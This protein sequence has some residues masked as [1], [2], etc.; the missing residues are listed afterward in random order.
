MNRVPR[1]VLILPV[2]VAA[3][4][5]RIG[6]QSADRSPALSPELAQ[7]VAQDE[8]VISDALAHFDEPQRLRSVI[9]KAERVLEIRVAQQGKAWWE[10][11]DARQN[12]ADLRSLLAMPADQRTALFKAEVVGAQA[13]ELQKA[14]RYDQAAQ[15]LQTMAD[16]ERQILGQDH[17]WYAN[18][19]IALGRLYDADAQGKYAQAESLFKRALAIE[20]RALGQEHP[21]VAKALNDL[22]FVFEMT[23]RY[24]QAEPLCRQALEIR[25][26]ALGEKH[27]DSLD[28]LHRLALIY[29]LMDRNEEAEPLYRELADLQESISGED[30]PE[31][32]SDLTH[33]GWVEQSLKRYDQAEALYRKSL[34]IRRKVL[35]EEHSGVAENLDELGFLC[36]LQNRYDEAEPLYRQALQIRRKVLG[37]EHPDTLTSLA[38]LAAL[39]TSMTRY[40]DAEP[41]Y[42]QLLEVRRKS[43][44]EEHPDY[45]SAL[46]SLAW[47]NQ[48]MKRYDEAERL[49][50]Q[51]L[52]VR[53]RTRGEEDPDYATAL[54]DLGFLYQSQ[55]R[56]KEAEPLYR[57]A[58][59]IR[60]KTLGTQHPDTLRSLQKLADLYR[61]SDRYREAEPL[62]L[63][64][65]QAQK[66]GDTNSLDYAKTLTYLASVYHSLGRFGEEEP[67]LRQ[68]IEIRKAAG[69]D[70]DPDYARA[71]DDLGVCLLLQDRN[72]EAEPL[73]LQALEIRK[74]VLGEKH[75]DYGYSLR[76]MA[77][78]YTAVGQ[79]ERADQML[80]KAL[81]IQREADGNENPYYLADLAELY[82]RQ[83]RPD[84]AEPLF[85][86][87]LEVD[88]K[89]QAGRPQ[90]SFLSSL[91][92]FY[93]ST[94]RFG[95]AEPLLR[96]AMEIDREKLG[97][98]HPGY[99]RDLQLLGFLYAT[100]GRHTLAEPLLRQA[101][102]ITRKS[103]GEN[104]RYAGGLFVLARLYMA[105]HR[106]AEAQ[107]LL[108]QAV[109]IFKG[110]RFEGPEYTIGLT[111]LAVS[112]I[113]TG[114]REEAESLARQ[115]LA[116]RTKSFGTED[117]GRAQI[118]TVLA[119][120]LVVRSPSEAGA[121]LVEA[122][123]MEW[124]Y[125]ARNFPGMGDRQK[126]EF[127]AATDFASTGQLLWMLTFRNGGGGAE[128]G[129]RV[130]LLE[131]HLLF[132]SARQES[133]ALLAAVVAA[134][135]QWRAAWQQR[136]QLRR[137]YA[138][139]ALKSMSAASEIPGQEAVDPGQLRAFTSR[140]EQM[141]QQLRQS[142]PA[143]AL[144]AGIQ[145]IRL[146]DVRR[147]VRP[148]E[149][150]V[151]YLAYPAAATHGTSQHYGAFV[152]AG[153]SG[154]VAAID[155]GEAAAVDEAVSE[156]RA[157]VR[158]SIVQFGSVVPSRGQL[159]RSETEIAALS[160]QVRALVWQPLEKQLEGVRRVY[161]APDGQLSLIPFEALAQ[162][163]DAG[164]WRYL[165]EDRELIYLG[166]GRD[167][168]RL[169]LSSGAAA[170]RPKTAVLI[171]NPDFSAKPEQLAAEV[172]GIEPAVPAAV[173]QAA[174]PPTASTLGIAG[175]D[176]A[177]RLKIPRQWDRR[178]ELTKLVEGAGTQL[179][180]LG[181][182]VELL[183]GAA[184]VKEA[185][186][187][188]KAPRILQFATHGY[189][190]DRPRGEGASWDNPLLRSMLILA[191]ANDW[192]PVYRVGREFLT[193]AAARSKGLD[194]EQLRAARVDL[195]DGVLTAYEVTGMNLWGT[196]LVNL[197]ACETG[198]G[199]VTPEG[200]AGLREAFL[201][202]G[203]RSLTVSMWE[204]PGEET[205]EEIQ[206]FY[207]RWLGQGKGGRGM[208]RYE[209]FHAA[210]LAALTRARESRGVGHPFYWAGVVFMGDPGDLPVSHSR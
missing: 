160:S 111:T 19:L 180:R 63:E 165:V 192:H 206:D 205:S 42:R 68:V 196:D 35:G 60:R 139:L 74:N 99:L 210:Q 175:G 174:R 78:L 183:T 181:W 128:T 22:C 158:E 122:A 61:W 36:W 81:E 209:A 136:E 118:L 137:Q 130:A 51:L 33:L 141:D 127:L 171:G 110:A 12:L 191:G 108:R 193:E 201:L 38:H 76:H 149:A 184:A 27:P 90:S 103:E 80:R 123:Q 46:S 84:R 104:T 53:R 64:L 106:E 163:V 96:E 55:D 117:L 150:L 116:I 73:M 105:E 13:A 75:S 124:K 135:P 109:A 87:A 179:K 142:N 126:Q 114:K 2:V 207:A 49:Y 92:T 10:T 151:E 166:T 148:G 85:R 189:V 21:G 30:N 178:P 199:E 95:E 131:K 28:S 133:G 54:T 113:S 52:D 70:Q 82:V 47:V 162:K 172:T 198:L 8:K 79:V 187:A 167:L 132:E 168:A 164:N 154:K 25:R 197:T 7:Q 16:A 44:G 69:G 121:M 177:P 140:I 173:A 98:Q 157:A 6:G 11:V 17:L 39:Y 188:V 125:L 43:L 159:R 194:A 88:R 59:E 200:V 156:F 147:A 112:L 153:G 161:V 208:K 45:A 100:T 32:A 115:A 186:E 65:A 34:A 14:G 26:K 146:E 107:P 31:Y 204:V 145:E 77:M 20:E 185:V 202:A 86:R 101:L 62:Y 97:E 48:C 129:L 134:P 169:A 89:K 182:S 67:A 152:L 40:P 5:T 1:R 50:R 102:N 71:L 195:S 58:L 144:H 57:Q 138:A 3:L 15:A 37:T 93:M 119:A 18:S 72:Q 120:S 203:A 23:E 9:P 4:V 66:T 170:S 83:G 190:L 155:L 29:G 91:G 56:Y 94:G 176:E 41:L 143:Y 24:P